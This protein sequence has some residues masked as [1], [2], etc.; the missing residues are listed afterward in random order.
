MAGDNANQPVVMNCNSIDEA[1]RLRLKYYAY[2]MG[3]LAH[4]Q[5]Y[6]FE[7]M[8]LENFQLSIQGSTLIWKPGKEQDDMDLQQ[9]V[10]DAAK[11]SGLDVEFVQPQINVPQEGIQ[12]LAPDT[13]SK[14]ET[15]SD[16]LAS[17]A[18]RPKS[19]YDM[20]QGELERL[21]EHPAPDRELMAYGKDEANDGILDALG[22]S[23]K[24]PDDNSGSK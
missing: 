12:I 4:R 5:A 16:M 17:E 18:I 9:R 11:Q 6:S 19:I 23:P 13:R 14:K 10:Y 22:L 15:I 3:I 8:I 2:R 21:P 7:A 24:K 20:T 1:R